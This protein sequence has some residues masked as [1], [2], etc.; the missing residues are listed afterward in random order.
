MA[1]TIDQ[2]ALTHVLLVHPDD[3]RL[4]E[5]TALLQCDGFNVVGCCD[6]N[7]GLEHLSGRRFG[8]AVVDFHLLDASPTFEERLPVAT[9][10]ELVVSCDETTDALR[11]RILSVA[12]SQALA[13]LE[14]LQHHDLDSV[15]LQKQKLESLG[16][17]AS[18]IAHDFNNL[19]TA[20][21][22]HT[23]LAMEASAEAGPVRE[24][25]VR[26]DGVTGKAADL[27]RQLLAYAGKGRFLFEDVDLN[28]VI[29][30]MGELLSTSV[31]RDATL[32][33]ELDNH[34]SQIEADETQ[35]SQVVMNLIRNAADSFAGREGTIT[36]RTRHSTGDA[37]RRRES[38][39]GLYGDE[40]RGSCVVLEV[41][42][43]GGGIDPQTVT[44][45]FDPFS[46]T[47]GSGRGLGLA[48][49]LGIVRGHG[50][51]IHVESV[52]G[53]GTTFRVLFPTVAI[54]PDETDQ[55]ATGD[56]V[57]V[58]VSEEQMQDVVVRLLRRDGHQVVEAQT[59]SEGLELLGQGG[60][61]I[62][63]VF[64]DLSRADAYCCESVAAIRK[65]RFDIPVVVSVGV[66][67]PEVTNRLS[68]AG[69]IEFLHKPFEPH[70]LLSTMR[71]VT[72]VPS[73][74]RA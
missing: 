43:D 46:T 21:Q 1:G 67:G 39:Q 37:E 38:P 41:S 44:R 48:T 2:T 58:M 19:L 35:L 29:T 28:A 72:R 26:I 71:S 69:N 64:V 15:M 20:M 23:I 53:K 11:R 40:V 54:N 25:L 45:I 30:Q 42:D 61:E 4:A 17:L 33:L 8:I 47:K 49:V 73:E 51:A 13:A 62:A 31:G 10:T 36:V 66:E 5:L 60:D 50:A 59:E 9:S 18:G 27:C 14:Q 63:A 34:L 68:E 7:A 74:R 24:H 55:N 12:R 22:G 57:L 6:L 3:D 52:P 56:T 70:A 16:L 32:I 65:L